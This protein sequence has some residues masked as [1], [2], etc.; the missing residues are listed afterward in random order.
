MTVTRLADSTLEKCGTFG[1]VWLVGAVVAT[2]S[3]PLV[4]LWKAS[5]PWLITV[6][7]SI[8]VVIVFILEFRAHRRSG[9]SAESA[10]GFVA[11]V[12]SDYRGMGWYEGSIALEIKTP[13]KGPKGQLDMF[14]K[15]NPEEFPQTKVRVFKD[16]FGRDVYVIN[17]GRF[18]ELM[19]SRMLED[20]DRAAEHALA[21]AWKR[22]GQATSNREEL[23]KFLDKTVRE[24]IKSD[25]RG[26]ILVII[27]KTGEKVIKELVGNVEESMTQEVTELPISSP[28]SH[29]LKSGST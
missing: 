2:V 13:K 8:G 22:Y 24:T 11:A 21:V 18:V 23:R 28:P 3:T 15:M 5:A 9:E 20:V 1:R 17:S 14:E 12:S 7:I 4:V 29:E 10:A 19:V 25:F 26:N 16:S 6:P 27:S